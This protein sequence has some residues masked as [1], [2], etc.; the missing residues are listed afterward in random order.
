MS[1]TGMAGPTE[2]RR[3]RTAFSFCIPAA[4]QLLT[5]CLCPRLQH[6]RNVSSEKPRRQGGRAGEASREREGKSL[7]IKGGVVG[8]M[9]GLLAFKS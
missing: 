3:S 5:K 1:L 8:E 2:V 6:F 9:L 4:F 7:S